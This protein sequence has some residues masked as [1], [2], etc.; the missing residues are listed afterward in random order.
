M[1]FKK[2]NIEVLEKIFKKR[3]DCPWKDEFL[4]RG[5]WSEVVKIKGVYV[6]RGMIRFAGVTKWWVVA[7]RT[8]ETFIEHYDDIVKN[9]SE[10]FL[11]DYK[12]KGCNRR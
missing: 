8:P 9:I 1:N 4:M 3:L 6:A 12:S 7:L 10:K 11:M 2:P 5:G